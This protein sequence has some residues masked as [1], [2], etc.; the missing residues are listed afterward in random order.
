MCLTFQRAFEF[1][2]WVA[3]GKDHQ[4]N[5]EI[6]SDSSRVEEEQESSPREAGLVRFPNPLAPKS[7]GAP[8]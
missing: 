2:A 7:G 4:D 5:K 3:S 8:V 1:K 6:F